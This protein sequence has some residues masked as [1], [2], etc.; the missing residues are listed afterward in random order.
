MMRFLELI[1]AIIIVAVAAVIAGLVMPGS[2][3]VERSLTMGKDMHQVYDMLDNFRRFPDYAYFTTEDPHIHYQYSGKDYG[4]GA[5]ISWSGNAEKV[6]SGRLTIAS[7]Q[8]DFNKIDSTVRTAAIVWNLTNDWRGHDKKFTL[9]MER[10]G[11]TNK[12]TRVTWN[13]DV[14]Y[15]WNLID[16]YSRLYIH[17]APDAFAQ[18][19]LQGLQSV[20][21]GVPNVDYND[22]IPYIVQTKPTPV[23]FVSTSIERKGGLDALDE[24]TA[25]AV[26]EIQAAAKKLGVNVVGPRTLITTNYGDQTYKFDVAM[27][28]DASSLNLGGQ[29]YSLTAPRPPQLNGAPAGAGSAPAQAA[30]SVAQASSSEAPASATSSAAAANVASGPAPGS[31]DEAGHLI[32]NQNVK[33][34]LAFGGAALRAEW[35]GTFAGVPQTR[36]EMQAYAL[37]HGYKFDPV[38]H[39]FY[40]VL[41]K[42]QVINTDN[43][44]ASYA[45]Y[46]VYLPLSEAPEQ[47]PEQAAGMHPPQIQQ[48]DQTPAASGTAATPAS[49]G[50]APAAA[51]TA[52]APAAGKASATHEK[53]KAHG[54]KE[55]RK[56]E[57]KRAA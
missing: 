32:I 4:P 2:G 43:T 40:D 7:N 42:P 15:G 35:N 28:I 27:V 12:L 53:R 50:S 5:E 49:S 48:P 22:L 34:M 21:A 26:Q 17:G 25:T 19:S 41:V 45:K 31:T 11:R 38:V 55:K 29:S 47:T 20:L 10:E 54:R 14:N 46:E 51:G 39:R 37:T 6:G 18:Y 44:V 9:D 33:A 13:Y 36:D 57:H 8:P 30:S 16:R 56:R 23:L 3:H 24:A 1:V 52:A